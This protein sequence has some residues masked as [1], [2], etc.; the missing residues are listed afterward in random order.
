MD[1]MGLWTRFLR[2]EHYDGLQDDPRLEQ[3]EPQDEVDGADGGLG[4]QAYERGET[5]VED[6]PWYPAGPC[7]LEREPVCR[8][9][10][11][12][13]GGAVARPG[14]GRHER[15]DGHED[16]EETRNDSDIVYVG[17]SFY[18]SG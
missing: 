2:I 13:L 3:D 18:E 17:V 5:G 16:V 4:E 7:I 14:N 15:Q 8:S 1:E 10:W 9:S 11:L 12:P 6:T